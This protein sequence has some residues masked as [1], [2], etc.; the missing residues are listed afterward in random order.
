MS[1][2][3]AEA[4]LDDSVTVVAEL[5]VE[6]VVML[7]T[8]GQASPLIVSVAPERFLTF[9]ADKVL[10]TVGLPQGSD[11][12]VL[13]GSPAGPTDWDVHLVMTAQTVQL[14]HLLTHCSTPSPRSGPK[15]C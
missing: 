15:F 6:L 3:S 7:G 8:V 11:D 9:G 10:H 14:V 4:C 12:P 1:V 2:L 5:P 13:Y